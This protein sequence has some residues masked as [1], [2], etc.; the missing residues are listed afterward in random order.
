[1][2]VGFHIVS[3]DGKR[4]LKIN[5]E[6]EIGVT[7]HSHPPINEQVEAYPFSQWFTDNGAASGSNDLRVDGSST[8]QDFYICA[9]SEVDIFVKSISVRI[10]DTSAVLNKFGNLTALTNGLEFHYSTNQLG[11]VV[12]QDEIKTNLDFI[13]IGLSTGAVGDG[14]SAFR[15]DLS[16]GGADTYLPVIDLAVTF[17]FPWGLR[18]KKASTD[19]IG[20]VVKDDLSTGIDAFNIKGFGS[21]L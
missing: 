5:G 17:G 20:F 3:G 11:D 2:T 12:I 10:S 7:V 21:Q 6:G 14:T 15:S 19:C 13:R 9:S 16:G 1:M 4:T 18:L 8:N